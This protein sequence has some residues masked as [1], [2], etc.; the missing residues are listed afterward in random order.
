MLIQI[1]GIYGCGCGRP[2]LR[3]LKLTL[4]QKGTTGIN[5]FLEAMKAKSYFN[6]YEWVW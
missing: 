6:N 1:N 3:T 2:G 5:W 4:S